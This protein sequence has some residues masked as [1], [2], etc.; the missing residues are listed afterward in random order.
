LSRAN[1]AAYHIKWLIGVRGVR[2]RVRTRLTVERRGAIIGCID[3]DGTYGELVGGAENALE[4]VEQ[5]AASEPSALLRCDGEACD[6]CHGYREV[7]GESLAHGG[8]CLLVLDLGGYE[9]LR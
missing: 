8:C 4:R 6:E 5:K 9:G 7:A 2:G 3:S 1:R